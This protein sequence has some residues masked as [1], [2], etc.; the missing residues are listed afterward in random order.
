[1]NLAGARGTELPPPFF[2]LLFTYNLFSIKFLYYF[3]SFSLIGRVRF[4]ISLQSYGS[5]IRHILALYTRII[6][7][8]IF[9]EQKVKRGNSVSRA[10]VDEL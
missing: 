5:I 1:M 10:S 8:I 6:H 2:N 7:I 3:I 4:H 9:I